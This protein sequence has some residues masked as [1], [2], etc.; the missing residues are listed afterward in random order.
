[1]R[2]IKVHYFA[3]RFE[4]TRQEEN[5]YPPTD[6]QTKKVISSWIKNCQDNHRGCS[7]VIQAKS[8]LVS[9]SNLPRRLLDLEAKEN[10][11]VVML[12]EIEQCTSATFMTLS[13]C[14]GDYLPTRL[15]KENHEDFAKGIMVMALPRTFQHAIEFAR[16]LK[17]R[18]LWIDALCIIQNSPEDWLGEA[19][20]MASIY[21]NS[22]LNL[23]ATSAADGHGGLFHP[24]NMLLTNP[25]S[26][27]ATW[28]GLAPGQHR[29]FDNSARKRRVEAGPL[30]RRAWVLQERLLAPRTAHFAYDQIWWE[31]RCTRASETM[32]TGVPNA[33]SDDVNPILR[34]FEDLDPDDRVGSN[35]KWLKWVKEY[36]T[37]NMTNDSD[38]LAALAGIASSVQGRLQWPKEEYLAGLWSQDL[39]VNLLWALNGPGQK[40]DEYVAPSWSWASVKGEIIFRNFSMTPGERRF[41]EN[42]VQIEI[43]DAIVEPIGTAL[44][45]VKNG[46]LIIRGA[47]ASV[48]MSDLD[49]STRPNPRFKRLTLNST[50]LIFDWTSGLTVYLDDDRWCTKGSFDH[51]KTY[52]CIFWTMRARPAAPKPLV[53][54]GLLLEPTGIE[55][56]QYRRIGRFIFFTFEELNS[57]M[58]EWELDSQEYIKIYDSG[59]VSFK[60]V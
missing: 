49:L 22:Y 23:A 34:V 14:W 12:R 33:A 11:D 24:L 2:T 20:R 30:N 32:P 28:Q 57:I 48:T 52:L 27:N 44:G 21:S 26:I 31:C 59:Q 7:R 15:L 50:K 46:H 60:I 13:H 39:A 40:I 5:I 36:T 53:S 25:C 29:I 19:Q 3:Y 45:P 55:R 10:P 42:R 58:K 8:S 1:M 54:E 17:I 6:D 18:Y 41:M 35:A 43:L 51:R 38:K 37:K 56:G 16:A 9:D 4:D 47:L